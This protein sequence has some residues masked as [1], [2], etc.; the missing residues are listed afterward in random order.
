MEQNNIQ[1]EKK[2]SRK[3]FLQICG[4]VLA[5]GSI[6][7]VS[8]FS[9]WKIVKANQGGS[10]L[11][12]SVIKPV[13][14]YL[15]SPYKLVSSFGTDRIEAFDLYQG[16]LFVATPNAISIYD[17]SGN[18][19]DNF[20]VASQVRDMVVK[21]DQ[22]Y[23]LYPSH[24]ELYTL[25]GDLIR[26]WEAC[27]EQSDYCSL[28]V[29]SGYLFATDVAMKHIAQY[30]D[31]G[32]FVRFIQSP[33]GFIIPSYSFGIESIGE[34]LYCSNPGRHLVESYS[35]NGEYLGAFGKPGGAP[36][37]FAGC[38]NPVHIAHSP[39]GEIITSE[40]GN[41]RIS[42]YSPDGQFRSILLDKQLLGGGKTAYDV[43]LNED[44]M[45]VAGNG[46]VSVFHFDPLLAA[47]TACSDCGVSCP[48]RKGITI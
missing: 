30:R 28:A 11:Q 27:S 20:P 42:C 39:N 48:L 32:N 23:I 13:Q 45:Y 31:D 24:I 43:K 26:D 3:K 1:K 38:C 15:T 14:E 12:N 17:T 34:T 19:L 21:D 9:L 25:A 35:V 6:L 46:M 29:T 5:G 44:K 18:L 4:S 47:H 16:K 40:K 33:N 41:P 7:S 22:I 37:L 2:I 8:G 10:P 36:G